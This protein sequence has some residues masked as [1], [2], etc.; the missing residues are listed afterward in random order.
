MGTHY[1]LKASIR[2]I[3]QKRTLLSTR[4]TPALL[5]RRSHAWL[6]T[7]VVMSLLMLQPVFAQKQEQNLDHAPRDIPPSTGLWLRSRAALLG[8]EINDAGI[9]VIR[10]LTEPC[11]SSDGCR[12]RLEFVNPFPPGIIIMVRTSEGTNTRVTTTLDSQQQFGRIEFDLESS[13]SDVSEMVSIYIDP[14]GT[15]YDNDNPLRFWD[16]GTEVMVVVLDQYRQR[17]LSSERGQLEDEPIFDA[18]RSSLRLAPNP[19]T[20]LCHLSVRGDQDITVVLTDMCGHVIL[21]KELK[22]MTTEH[23]DLS[24]LPKGVYLLAN[25]PASPSGADQPPVSPIRVMIK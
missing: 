23:L 14:N 9:R 3:E 15:G 12:V 22:G 6:A 8:D 20:G 21:R 4:D 24:H 17:I 13:K 19:T 25:D 16:G 1:E 18:E 7:I 10:L 5:Y 2:P 11:L